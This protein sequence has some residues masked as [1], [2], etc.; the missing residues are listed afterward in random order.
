ME[1]KK[2]KDKGFLGDQAYTIIQALSI[3]PPLSSK[4]RKIYSAATA[5]QY[6]KDAMTRGASVMADGRLNLSPYYSI[7]GNLASATLNVPLDRV[8]DEVTSIVEATDARNTGWQRLALAL[9][10]KTWNVNAK[11]EEHDLLKIAGEAQRKKDRV[12]KSAATRAKNKAIE[13]ARLAALTPAER[14]AERRA[15][16]L[17]K[18]AKARA[19]ILAKRK[20]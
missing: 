14:A 2:Q 1:Y 19:K 9:G 6:N 3:S 8:V 12:A 20:K 4:V 10:W 5:D 17:E 15:T 11:N 13:K 16:A 7:F 18:R